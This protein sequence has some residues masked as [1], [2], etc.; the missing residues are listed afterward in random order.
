MF[1]FEIPCECGNYLSV[2]AS[3]AGTNKKCI[4]GRTLLIPSF[5]ELQKEFA[6]EEEPQKIQSD[7]TA[8]IITSIVIA[9]LLFVIWHW[10][11]K[12]LALLTC[13]TMFI[14]GK[15]WFLVLMFREMG[16]NALLVF[17]IPFFDWLFLFIRFDVA[18]R[19]VLL[20]F[21]GIIALVLGAM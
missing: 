15:V 3:Q 14:S 13:I 6:V 11:L 16:I 4:C 8:Y 21:I 1:L 7:N 12:S 2:N 17:I 9:A 20:Q 18:W 19:P 5:G 10:D